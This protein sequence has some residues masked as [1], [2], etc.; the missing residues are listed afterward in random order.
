[1]T[2]VPSIRLNTRA[3]SPTSTLILL[4]AF[5]S[6]LDPGMLSAAALSYHLALMPC[7]FSTL[8]T[9]T[10]ACFLLAYLTSAD[11]RTTL[12]YVLDAAVTAYYKQVP[13]AS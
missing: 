9:Y 2:L 10:I 3:Q 6:S 4:T 1:M 13:G 7:T 8:A 12:I 11:T 5:G